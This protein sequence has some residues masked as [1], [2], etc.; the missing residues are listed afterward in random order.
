VVEL[1]FLSRELA[2]ARARG[3]RVVLTNGCFDLLHAGHVEILEDAKAL[4]DILVV[5]LNSDES[6]SALKGPGRPVVGREQRA[7]CLAALG[8]V[9]FVVVFPEA[10]P[11]SLIEALHPDVLVKGADYTRAQV[12]GG[13]V[14]EAYGGKVELLPLREGVSTTGILRGIVG[15]RT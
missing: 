2:D 11:L 13:D 9:D 14:V 10:T 1:D 12:V 8:C 6:V 5:A 7:L 3:R 4:G 15:N